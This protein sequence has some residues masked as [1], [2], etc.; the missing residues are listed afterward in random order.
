MNSAD[1]YEKS[2]KVSQAETGTDT[3]DRM[4]ETYRESM[5]GRLNALSATIEG[6]FTKA[7]NTDDF[8]GLIDAAQALADTFDNLIQAIGGGD[9]A[10][11]ALGAVLTKVFSKNIA[12]G[13]GNSVLNR[14]TNQMARA[15]M[16]TAISNARMIAA[17]NGVG[18]DSN[19]MDAMTLNIANVQKNMGSASN[20]Q[21]D[22]I[23]VSVEKHINI[24]TEAA[25]A[26]EKFK[27]A[28]EATEVLLEANNEGIENAGTLSERYAAII[29]K[30]AN[31]EA[32]QQAYIAAQNE[33]FV[34]L[35]NDVTQLTGKI[36]ELAVQF[37]NLG[38]NEQIDEQAM[39]R[40]KD[41][42]QQLNL[43]TKELSES[44]LISAERKEQLI[45]LSKVLSEVEK[46]EIKDVEQLK[47][48][49]EQAGLDTAKFAEALAALSGEGV[50][51]RQVLEQL[52]L[53]QSQLGAAA[54]VS[55]KEIEGMASA[56]AAQNFAKGIANIASGSMNILFAA[57]SIRGAFEA[58]NNEDLDPFEK[59]E[60]SLMGFSMAAA[61]AAPMIA[62]LIKAIREK[63]AIVKASNLELLRQQMLETNLAPIILKKIGLQKVEEDLTK[64][65]TKEQRMAFITEK[66]FANGKKEVSRS[67]V[68]A[69][70]AL[71]GQKAA[72][73]EA[74]I[75]EAGGTVV[76][77][78]FAVAFKE[79]AVSI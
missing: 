51:I 46:K 22:K 12:Q 34:A 30:L 1:I 59:M 72:V 10:L 36:S 11:T 38:K 77:R 78:G 6:I 64:N 45:K 62:N 28:L 47:V 25:V 19:R 33:L 73:I 23:N 31:A 27:S 58:M 48:A 54:A 9:A 44:E 32:D 60:Q 70:A 56:L 37:E 3:Y 42:A 67:T 57:Q 13:I 21:I 35:E 41:N 69:I 26:E 5:E 40:L 68:A 49:L 14:Q 79:L 66:L 61:M 65:T 74:E 20:E 18:L 39:Q 75:A 7:F 24:M 16:D 50:N 76:T 17:Q 63:N 29:E 53:N 8:Y 43:I 71:T 4:Q 2:L 55:T 15:N 52:A